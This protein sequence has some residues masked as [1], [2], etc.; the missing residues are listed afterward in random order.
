MQRAQVTSGSTTKRSWRKM[1]ASVKIINI[2]IPVPNTTD[3]LDEVNHI[4][5]DHIQPTKI[6][7]GMVFII[8][9]Q[10]PD[11]GDRRRS[12]SALPVR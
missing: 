7:G 10:S 6:N 3:P 9:D 11:I 8:R 12:D 4:G 5:G 1:T 2:K